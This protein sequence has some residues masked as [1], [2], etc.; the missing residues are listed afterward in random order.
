MSPITSVLILSKV[1]LDSIKMV[2]SARNLKV[3]KKKKWLFGAV[4]LHLLAF[5]S[6]WNLLPPQ[7]FGN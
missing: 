1:S 7:F 2:T 4:G 3:K 5:I 6:D